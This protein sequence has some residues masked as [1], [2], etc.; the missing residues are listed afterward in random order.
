MSKI[1]LTYIVPCYNIQRY[2]P[3]CL[4]SLQK[5]VIPEGNL[6]FIIVNDGSTDDS[7]S[8]I[9]HFASKDKRIVIVDQ[10][11]YGVCVARNNGLALAKGDFVFFLDGDD[12]LPDDASEKMYRFCKAEKLD[13][14]LFGNYKIQEGQSQERIW[15][16][17]TRFISQGIYT[18]GQFIDNTTYFPISCKLYRRDFLLSNS[19]W[20]DKQLITGE[21]YTFFIHALMK[22]EI[23]GV[24]SDFVMYY[25]KRKGESATTTVNIQRDLSVLDTLHTVNE[26]VKDNCARLMGKRSYLSSVFWLVT[27]FSLIKYVGR[28]TY[29]KEIGQLV[30]RVKRDKEYQELLC[31]LT[32]R[33]FSFTKH[34]YLALFIRFFPPRISYCLIRSYYRVVTRNKYETT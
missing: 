11:N 18:R 5:Q 27:S 17:C 4:E 8:V 14:V 28:T 16:D 3:K 34:S 9:Q 29:T 24:S 33:G 19:V 31:Y 21:V 13:I 12:W 2:L 1:F 25:L 10:P 7:L 26:Y 22:S 20:F 23:V 6:E 15:V 32:G 30:K